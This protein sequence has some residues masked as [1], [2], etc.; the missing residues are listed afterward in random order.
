MHSVRAHTRSMR[1]KRPG[2]DGASHRKN[3]TFG[4]ARCSARRNIANMRKVTLA[5]KEKQQDSAR[6]LF[7][8][9]NAGVEVHLETA[10]PL[11][12]GAA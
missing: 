12:C 2:T 5:G 3:A 4:S 9:G 8:I 1:S 11:L 10:K 6:N 7:Y